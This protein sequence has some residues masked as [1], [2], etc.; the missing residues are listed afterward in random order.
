M[1]GRVMVVVVVRVL[2]KEAMVLVN[3]SVVAVVMVVAMGAVCVWMAGKVAVCWV[4]GGIMVGG[5]V[6]ATLGKAVG[7]QPRGEPR[8]VLREGS[9]LG[10]GGGG[11]GE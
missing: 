10:M 2:G 6:E 5:G 9:S 11:L 3:L 4:V 1:V 8:L 7:R